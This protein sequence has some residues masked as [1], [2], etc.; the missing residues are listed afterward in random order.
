MGFF[1]KLADKLRKKLNNTGYVCD[2][3]GREVF[4]YP[5]ER[6]C[7]TC[8]SKMHREEKR[9]CEKCGRKTVSQGVCG[10]CKRRMPKFEKGISAFVYKGESASFINRTKNG[11]P[12]LALYFGERMAEKAKPFL[13]AQE[14]SWLIVPVPL[15][16][17]KERERGYNQAELLAE[18]VCDYLLSEGLDVRLDCGILTKL[19]DDGEQ[20]HAHFNERMD[21]AEK[22]YTVS[23]RKACKG[24]NVLLIDD[25]LT[26]G[27][28]GSGCADKLY[29]AGANRVVFLTACALE[30]QK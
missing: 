11:Y 23:N 13:Q 10:T 6:L 2:G 7:E 14:S 8:E 30:E 15:M 27:A 29:R 21:R 20:K 17:E 3:C 25:I 16:K 5:F 18:T 19:H 22:Q 28:T 4:H 9:L 24:A 26:T 12:R 1:S